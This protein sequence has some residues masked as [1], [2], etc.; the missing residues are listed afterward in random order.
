[1]SPLTISAQFAAYIWFTAQPQNANKGR[2]VAMQFARQRWVDFL[3]LANRGLGRLL[4]RMMRTP[5]QR[6]QRRAMAAVCH[7]DGTR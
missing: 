5:E 4:L 1:M 2:K 6:K 7:D 3:P